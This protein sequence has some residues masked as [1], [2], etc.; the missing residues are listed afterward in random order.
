LIACT[1]CVAAAC[2]VNNE[3]ASCNSVTWCQK[4]QGQ[5]GMTLSINL[6]SQPNYCQGILKSAQMNS[7]FLKSSIRSVNARMF[8]SHYNL[9]CYFAFEENSVLLLLLPIAR[10]VQVATQFCRTAACVLT[11]VL[12]LYLL[13]DIS[14]LLPG[15]SQLGTGQRKQ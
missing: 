2:V 3:F 7:L 15:D 8:Q 13:P 12:T 14:D 10:R 4:I 11:A 1:G 9:C 5:L 6:L